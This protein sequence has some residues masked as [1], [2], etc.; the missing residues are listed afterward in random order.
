MISKE[1]L[2]EVLGIEVTHVT[3]KPELGN[4][5]EVQYT[6]GLKQNY[7]FEANIYELMHLMKKWAYEQRWLVESSVTLTTCRQLGKD[8]QHYFD[9]DSEYDSVVR[10]CQWIYNK[11]CSN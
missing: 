3:Q 9:E 8:T 11:R 4:I 1:L 5:L 2:S 10:A 7:I 6:N